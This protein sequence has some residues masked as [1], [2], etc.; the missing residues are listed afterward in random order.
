MVVADTHIIIWNALSPKKLSKK[1]RLQFDDAN[2]SDGIIFC[3]I[4]LWEISMLIEKK[5]L[6]IDV[7]FLEF[8]DLIKVTT[9]YNFKPILPEI[10][11]ISA[12]LSSIINSD[13]ADRLLAAT[14]LYFNVPLITADKNLIQSNYINTIW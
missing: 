8:I 14:S 12:Q 7:P 10:A 3:D 5:R 2:E 11:D 4:S 13:P 6:V 9:N 1:A